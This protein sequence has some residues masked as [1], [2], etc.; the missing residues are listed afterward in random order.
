MGATSV[1]PAPQPHHHDCL[2]FLY[3]RL[4]P[5]QK[6]FLIFIIVFLLIVVA[7]AAVVPPVYLFVI[8]QPIQEC[9]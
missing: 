3:S 7:A 4:T 9:K 6:T 8:S 5:K 1:E 2:C